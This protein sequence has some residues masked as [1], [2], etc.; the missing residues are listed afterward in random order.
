MNLDEIFKGCQQLW[1]SKPGAVV[2]VVL[3]FV[4]F[5]LL[6]VDVRRHKR[7]RKRPH[8]HHP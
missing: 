7:Q 8:I 1:E 6:V 2:L 5:L 3:G 4:V